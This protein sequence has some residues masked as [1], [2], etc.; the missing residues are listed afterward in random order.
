MQLPDGVGM[1]RK[2]AAHVHVPTPA[3]L[4]SHCSRQT[5]STHG[6]F[7]PYDVRGMP[8]HADTVGGRVVVGALVGG[9]VVWAGA[10]VGLL[11]GWAV[12]AVGED[13]GCKVGACVGVGVGARVGMG[14]VG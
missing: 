13:M 7:E 9:R 6:S 11:V 1:R 10:C 5:T 2:L 12:G 3:A 8:A 4:T 14:V